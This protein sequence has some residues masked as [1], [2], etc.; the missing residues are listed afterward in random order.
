MKT[1]HIPELKRVEDIS[2]KNREIALV[3]NPNTGKSCLFNNLTGM[4]AVVSNY[5]GTTVDVIKGDTKFKG[6]TITIVDLPGIYSMGSSSDEELVAKEYLIK[7]KPELIINL[8][9]A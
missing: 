1:C 6:K 7:K 2:K 8:V 3:G 5:P 4:G 9:D